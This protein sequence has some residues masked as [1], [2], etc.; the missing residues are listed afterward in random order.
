M[1]FAKSCKEIEGLYNN[2]EYIVE[3]EVENTFFTVLYGEPY[4]VM[5][6]KVNESLKKCKYE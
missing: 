2:S 1:S 4:T 3:G 5:E 6:L